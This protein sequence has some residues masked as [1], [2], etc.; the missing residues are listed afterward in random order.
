A[1]L[2]P[3][4]GLTQLKEWGINPQLA[5]HLG[6]GQTQAGLACCPRQSLNLS[7]HGMM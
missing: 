5:Q 4:D 7:H 2:T 3:E 6:S 1:I